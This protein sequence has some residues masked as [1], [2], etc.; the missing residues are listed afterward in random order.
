MKKKNW[1]VIIFLSLFIPLLTGGSLAK[2]DSSSLFPQQKS[3]FQEQKREEAKNIKELLPSVIY[4]FPP[5]NE[6]LKG[7]TKLEVQVPE[8]LEIEF[9]LRQPSSLIEIYLGKG[10]KRG[11][12]WIL[13]IDTENIPNGEYFLFTKILSPFGSYSSQ[14][15]K[16]FVENIKEVSPD[17]EKIEEIQ[18]EL[19]PKQEE[20]LKKEAEIET[21]LKSS[22]EE[23]KNVVEETTKKIENKVP[24]EKREEA[25]KIVEEKI[26]HVIPEIQQSIK[27]YKKPIEENVKIEKQI[28]PPEKKE[29]INQ[30]KKEIQQK[31]FSQA[32]K[33]I[34]ETK[35]MI[36]EQEYLAI[37]KELQ[38]KLD[39]FFQETEQ[40]LK[41]KIREKS[42][43][44]SL[45]LK[46]S[47]G[48]GLS[49]WDEIRLGTN[50]FDPDSDGD[51]YLDSYEIIHGYDPLKP[52]SAEK[53][54]YQDP[55]KF[56]K[57]SEKLKI[58]KIEIVPLKEGKRGL[59]I[60]GNG[61]PNSFVTIYIFSSPIVAMVKVNSQGKFEYILD[62][63][64]SDGYHNVYL[65]LTNNK[66]EI[67]EKSTGYAFFKSGEQ[68]VRISELQ[69]EISQS[70]LE[71][72]GKGFFFLVLSSIFLGIS[73][74]F[75]ILGILAR[76][77]V[78]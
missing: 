16:I 58:E 61:I 49:D 70:P 36:P 10:E 45:T 29:K 8:A 68:L 71:R 35:E 22:E 20:L 51:G 21:I 19:L 65:A 26:K 30:E 31:I 43:I 37:K 62:K 5:E 23:I 34:E 25:K 14:E 54:V 48:D 59:K 46:D 42:E 27:E 15:V 38:N 28:L 4:L 72:L 17:V 40:I 69:A 47:D 7:K 55:K 78:E 56:G 53:V 1:Q 6:T 11:E 33:P 2:R 44:T 12:I 32:T 13:E 76:K 50:P 3:I 60:S 74:G 57:I 18:K 75:F 9:Y 24:P 63:D 67:Q 41:T 64:I 52:G 73:F 39:S 66:G 77:K